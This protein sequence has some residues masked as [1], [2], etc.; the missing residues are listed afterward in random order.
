MTA[1]QHFL[2]FFPLPQGHGSF[3][4]VVID[5]LRRQ[6]CTGRWQDIERHL[7]RRLRHLCFESRDNAGLWHF[8][9]L[10]FPLTLE[11]EYLCSPL[12]SIVIA[13]LFQHTLTIACND[14]LHV[15]QLGAKN[16]RSGI[17]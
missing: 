6:K 4:P 1:P 9:K 2:N 7:M 15:C 5:M 14:K 8:D 17:A 12:L 16:C 3:L 13:P 10:P 11:R